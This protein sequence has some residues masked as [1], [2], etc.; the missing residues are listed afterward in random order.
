MTSERHVKW[1][2]VDV[3]DIHILPEGQ[4]NRLIIARLSY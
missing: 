4:D 2:I 1:E 3:S